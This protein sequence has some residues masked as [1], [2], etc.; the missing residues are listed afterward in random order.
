MVLFDDVYDIKQKYE[1]QWM[2]GDIEYDDYHKRV[3][4][5]SGVFINKFIKD[6][7]D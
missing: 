7:F 4:K 2:D 1:K 6:F 5:E 3:E